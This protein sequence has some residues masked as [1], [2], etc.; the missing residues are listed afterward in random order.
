[1]AE[2]KLQFGKGGAGLQGESSIPNIRE[3]LVGVVDDL[4]ALHA[5]H[6]ALTAKL[7]GEDVA[8]LD[9]NY[10]ATTDPAALTTTVES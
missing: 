6:L 1:M 8:N 9:T 5:A 3:V 2:I 4:A 10:A 7:D